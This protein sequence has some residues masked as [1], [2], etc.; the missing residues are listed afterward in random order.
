MGVFRLR[1][2]VRVRRLSIGGEVMG[3]DLG[4]EVCLGRW[5]WV[6]HRLGWDGVVG[7]SFL[8]I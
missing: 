5:I 7:G 8:C 2:G 3:K 6:M 4:R 1:A